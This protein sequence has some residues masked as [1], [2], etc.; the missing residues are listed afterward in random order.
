MV[1]QRPHIAYKTT[2]LNVWEMFFITY[3]DF[4]RIIK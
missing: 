3:A 2:A 4:I 1:F